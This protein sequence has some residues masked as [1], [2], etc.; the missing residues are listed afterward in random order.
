MLGVVALVPSLP[1]AS[2]YYQPAG[3]LGS[4]GL[5]VRSRFD[6]PASGVLDARLR[7][8]FWGATNIICRPVIKPILN[9][10]YPCEN[11]NWTDPINERVNPKDPRILEVVKRGIRAL[12]ESTRAFHGLED[13]GFIVTNVSGTAHT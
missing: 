11:A 2:A 4:P 12:F 3:A 9:A 13:R 7:A 6:P 10:K 5:R 1:F 8:K